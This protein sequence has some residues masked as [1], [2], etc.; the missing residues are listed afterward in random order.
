MF[1][2]ERLQDE[3]ELI[4]QIDVRFQFTANNVNHYVVK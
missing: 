2:A 4:V 3:E 1:E